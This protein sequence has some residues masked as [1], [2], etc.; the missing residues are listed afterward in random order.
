M[1]RGKYQSDEDTIH[2][3]R[4]STARLAAAGTAP[5]AAVNSEINVKVSK[6][7]RE[8]GIRPRGVTL[9]KPVNPS[10]TDKIS[11]A[12]LPVL[13]PTAFDS[14]AFKKDATVTIGTVQW[15]I[16]ARKPEDY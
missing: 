8:F 14:D 10:A 12:F 16:I 5:T 9:Q 3:I 11:Y 7:N 13:T 6:S 2:T 1:A 4:L 15:K